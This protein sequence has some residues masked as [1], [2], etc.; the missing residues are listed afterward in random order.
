[1]LTA[2]ALGLLLGLRHA[3]D[4]DHLV[5]VSAIASRRAG[6]RATAGVGLLWGL[7]HGATVLVAGGLLV[8]LGVVVPARVAAGLELGVAAVLIAIGISTLRRPSRSELAHS[9]LPSFGVGVVHGLAGTGAVAVL[10]TAAMPGPAEA[11][12]YLAVFAA[13]TLAGMVG[14]SLSLGA[15]LAWLSARPGGARAV[16]LASGLAALGFGGWMLWRAG[17]G[18]GLL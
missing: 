17:V 11:L 14:V 6:P 12:V 16:S 18:G 8:A 2:V 9:G 3:A 13:G 7:G 5:A 4:P 10:A 15:P 1:M